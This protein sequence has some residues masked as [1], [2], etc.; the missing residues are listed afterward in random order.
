ML[1]RPGFAKALSIY[2]RH[3]VLREVIP[4]KQVGRHLEM[5]LFSITKRQAMWVP[6]IRS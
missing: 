2:Y 3:K 5:R 4:S 6:D 1:G